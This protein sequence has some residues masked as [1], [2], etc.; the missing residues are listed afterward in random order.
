MGAAAPIPH[1][2]GRL[3]RIPRRRPLRHPKTP[4]AMPF[5]LFVLLPQNVNGRLQ[6][7]SW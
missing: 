1:A 3:I 7:F 6:R 4:E 5:A 2:P